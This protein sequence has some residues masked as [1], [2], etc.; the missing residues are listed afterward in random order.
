MEYFYTQVFVHLM[1]RRN[2]NVI[3]DVRYAI[4]IQEEDEN[5]LIYYFKNLFNII[6]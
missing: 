5:Y 1:N 2:L 6:T 3:V 4:E